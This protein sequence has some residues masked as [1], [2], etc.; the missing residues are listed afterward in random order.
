[1]AR[2]KNDKICVEP[3]ELSQKKVKRMKKKKDLERMRKNILAAKQQM[4]RSNRK[5]EKVAKS[6][7]EKTLNSFAEIRQKNVMTENAEMQ[8]DSSGPKSAFSA[9]K[10]DE[11]NTSN[12]GKTS[13][14]LFH[15]ELARIN[16][17][18][19]K[20]VVGMTRLMVVN[21]STAGIHVV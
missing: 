17:K 13:N 12:Y 21:R 8:D 4:K 10:N 15:R 19:V 9:A 3:S 14:G 2:F 5:Q 1:M 11:K 18:T 6:S 20:R 7:F 16:M